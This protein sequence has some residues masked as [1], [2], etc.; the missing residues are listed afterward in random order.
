MDSHSDRRK[1]LGRNRSYRK[2][3]NFI[4]TT[5][6]FIAS[7]HLNKQFC[8]VTTMPQDSSSAPSTTGIATAGSWEVS[9]PPEASSE[10]LR[11]AHVLIDASTVS[12][13]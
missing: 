12:Y 10:R 11:L 1:A 6:M 2:L 8:T 7:H 4:Q 13:R 5:H 9:P 3:L